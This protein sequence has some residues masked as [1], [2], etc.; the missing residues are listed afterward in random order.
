[1][2]LNWFRIWAEKSE[3]DPIIIGTSDLLLTSCSIP[4]P[5]SSLPTPLASIFL[6]L[7]YLLIF[8][9]LSYRPSCP[10]PTATVFLWKSALLDK[11]S[12]FRPRKWRFSGYRRRERGWLRQWSSTSQECRRPREPEEKGWVRWWGRR[13]VSYLIISDNIWKLGME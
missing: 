12:P 5:S 13:V 3:R 10:S 6:L 4:L 7:H 11:S 8:W 1:M 9:S 2:S